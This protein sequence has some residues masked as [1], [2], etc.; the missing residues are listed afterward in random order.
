VTVA[1]LVSTS[2]DGFDHGYAY[3]AEN[4]DMD[5]AGLALPEPRLLR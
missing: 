1:T 5:G 3:E 2:D 4:Q